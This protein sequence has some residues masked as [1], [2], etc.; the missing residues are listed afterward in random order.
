MTT[1][2]IIIPLYN[3]QQTI[4]QVLDRIFKV[5]FQHP[6][7]IDII[8]VDDCSTDDSAKLAQAYIAQNQQHQ[9]QLLTSQKNM[10]KGAAVRKGIGAATGTLLLIQDADLEYHPNDYPL[11]LTPFLEGVADVVFGSRFISNRPHRVLFFWHSMG[12]KFITLLSNIMTNLN[13]TDVECGYK[14]FNTEILKKII[15]KEKRFGIEPE[16]VAKIAAIPEVRIYEVGVSYYG[17]TY[18]E[19]KKI[20]LKDGFRALFCILKYSLFRR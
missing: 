17:R 10:G 13:L 4:I 20:G 19:G 14:I 2:S 15:L 3:E 7:K 11:L 8:I 9:I 16:I 18:A 12:N 6:I 1:L 5:Q